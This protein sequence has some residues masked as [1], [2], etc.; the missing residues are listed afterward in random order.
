MAS[1]AQTLH[2]GSTVTLLAPPAARSQLPGRPRKVELRNTTGLLRPNKRRH[3]E[4]QKM[5]KEKKKRRVEGLRYGIPNNSMGC[6]RKQALEDGTNRCN[7]AT[8]VSFTTCMNTTAGLGDAS[9]SDLKF[10]LKCNEEVSAAELPQGGRTT[11]T[12]RRA[13]SSQ[14]TN[15]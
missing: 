7:N 2:G 10:E 14:K 15:Q 1:Y 13:H 11:T 8:Q 12:R 5:S 4:S 3:P 6:T 9:G